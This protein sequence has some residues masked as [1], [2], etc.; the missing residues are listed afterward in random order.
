MKSRRS[1]NHVKKVFVSK[2]DGYSRH[3]KTWSPYFSAAGDMPE[4]PTPSGHQRI[5]GFTCAPTRAQLREQGRRMGAQLKSLAA[6]AAALLLAFVLASP[7]QAGEADDKLLSCLWAKEASSQL[8]P[9]DG[10]GGKAIGPYQIHRVYWQDAVDYDKSIGGTYQDCRDKI[11]AEKVVKAYLRRYT[12]SNATYEHMA[13][14]HNGGPN[15]HK[16]K[17]TE[18]YWKDPAFNQLR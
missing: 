8:N 9:R 1:Q 3:L 18:G 16:K 10:D 15:G 14:V 7:S 5:R 13:R 17:A 2:L 11:Y 4:L 6:V 12:P